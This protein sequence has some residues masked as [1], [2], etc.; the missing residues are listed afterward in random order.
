[1]FCISRLRAEAP[2]A[3]WQ[4][5][6]CSQLDPVW[7]LLGQNTQQKGFS[8]IDACVNAQLLLC[9]RGQQLC[10][11][12]FL[13]HIFKWHISKS[14]YFC[15]ICVNSFQIVDVLAHFLLVSGTRTLALGE[16]LCQETWPCWMRP[17]GDVVSMRGERG[18]QCWAAAPTWMSDLS[19]S[20][21]SHC[22]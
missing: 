7:R 1:M 13:M 2:S 20:N 11:L 3:W 15:G 22:G 4:T 19:F 14:S 21:T 17:S 6:K 8:A 5:H 16:P 10:T 9:L 18:R 12:K